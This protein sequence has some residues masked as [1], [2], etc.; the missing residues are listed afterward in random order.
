MANSINNTNPWKGLN[1][2]VEGEVLYGRDNEIESLS[3]FILNNTQTVLYG[4]SGI[5][6]S[7][8]LNAGIFPIARQN[9][10]IPVGIRLDHNSELSYIKQI[11]NAVINSGVDV[12]EIIPAV[13][14]KE[15]SLWEYMHR[16]IFFDKNGNR[17]QLLIVFDQFEEIF[18]LQQDEKKKRMFFHELAGLLNNVT[19]LY[20]INA[21]KKTTESTQSD[22]IEASDNLE[23]L[24]IDINIE[25]AIKESSTR[26][27]EKVD[28]HIVFTLRE[29]FL[30]YLE[31]YTAYI[32]VMKANRYA[33]LPINEEQAGEIIMSPRRGLISKEVAELIIQK[34][35]GKTDFKLDGVPEIDVD[36]AVLSLYLSRLFIKKGEDSEIISAELVNQFSDDIIKD[37]Y[38]ESVA[39]LPA[40]EI[41]NM[42][43]LLLTYDGRRNNVS[44]NDLI[45]EGIS[46]E[47][48]KTL[49]TDRKL[50][51]Q[52]SYQEDIRI[53]FMHDILCPVVNN[54][55]NQR[56]LAAQQEAEK[57]RQEQEH[58]ARLQEEELKRMALEKKAQ[59]Q[60]KRNRVRLTISL[61]LLF[62]GLAA[63]F[64][65][66]FLTRWQFSDYYACFTTKNGWPVGIGKKLSQEDKE[67]MPVF[68]E[69]IHYGY[70]NHNTRI[71]VLNNENKLSR[72]KFY[73]SPLVGLYEAESTDEHAKAFASYQRQTA[74]WIFTPDNDGNLSNMT[75]YS[76]NGKELY[77][78]QFFRSSS[79]DANIREDR[80]RESV[81]L[82]ANY[83]D[84][85]GKSLRVRDNGADRMR[86]I[87]DEQTGWYVG[88]QFFSELGTPQPNNEGAY[89]YRYQLDFDGKILKKQP[90]DEFGDSIH[91]KTVEYTSHDAFARWTKSTIG[92]ASYSRQKV[93]Y[94]MKDRT[95]SLKF[96]I[97]G[98]LTAHTECI[99]DSILT[100][101]NYSKGK[102]TRLSRYA[103]KG[104]NLQLVYQ[105]QNI[106][107]TNKLITEKRIC[108]LNKDST[109]CWPREIVEKSKGRQTTTYFEGTE[110][111]LKTSQIGLYPQKVSY[112][113]IVIDTTATQDG[114]VQV[115]HK[116][117]GKDGK[118]ISQVGLDPEINQEILY[119]N[120]RDE[121]VKRVGLQDSTIRYAYL[122]EYENGVIV[123]QA[124]AGIDGK[125][126]R[127]PGWDI[128]E[129]CYYKMKIVYDFSNTLVAVKGIN[130]FGEESLI[131]SG[132]KKYERN[133]TPAV[134]M[135][136]EVTEQGCDHKDI[137][138]KTH[139]QSYIP[140]QNSNM[141]KYIRI[142][143]LNGTWYK[144]GIRDGDLLLSNDILVKYA[145]PVDSLN[146]YVVYTIKPREGDPGAQYY[147]IYFNDKEF[148]R[149]SNA[150]NNKQQ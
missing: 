54:R 85:E 5:G 29:D 30:S 7:S 13:S 86:I 69:L 40:E 70:L 32:P 137:G 2:Y 68:Y 15:E 89:G 83:I 143:S 118:L 64:G 62:L 142:T 110:K 140:L 107:H 53:E 125:P 45:S 36:S 25:D 72:N 59:R 42:E 38:E 130:E 79:S 146:T 10:L 97:R 51:R 139:R 128:N 60:K 117:L 61:V 119:F 73:S 67:S 57:Q 63:W 74:Y 104:K 3:Q 17:R 88:Y 47:V 129:L 56:E 66:F 145:H 37:F 99:G 78:L 113:Q 31:R 122:F 49:V 23:N 18:T 4:K 101:Y 123:S 44:R 131:T 43:D 11:Q 9:G 1:F 65:W 115:T 50:L 14:E 93:V 28:Y 12:H 46:R 150:I 52:F 33:L 98:G 16:N 141:V 108:I 55:I 148:R 22:I 82:W 24:D 100:K 102:V 105:E 21:N 41:E 8:I 114:L 120:G 77:A 138:I 80:S 48:I 149:F 92:K 124:V 27:L 116:Y 20:I 84:K 144:S 39:D 6:K 134:V 81:Q 121:I 87:F 76:V 135:S 126:I 91:T 106:L 109:Y 132:T 26:Y 133:V 96:G 19:P 35:T 71:N 147:D 136:N 75:A 103:K 111:A 95:D 34:V 90:L 127:Y 58:Q 112:H 94:A